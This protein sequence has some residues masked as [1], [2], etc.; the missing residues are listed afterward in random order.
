MVTRSEDG[1]LLYPV[2]RGL[3]GNPLQ[4]RCP[5]SD[6]TRFT[7]PRLP[8]EARFRFWGTCV[9]LSNPNR[10]LSEFNYQAIVRTSD[11][12][13]ANYTGGIPGEDRGSRTGL[14]FQP[15]FGVG[16]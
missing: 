12:D 14:G 8:A 6:T 5:A 15:D 9:N 3:G 10:T 4:L 1:D 13:V 16:A 7:A 2:A 11:P